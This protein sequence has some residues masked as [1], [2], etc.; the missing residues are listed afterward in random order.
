MHRNAQKRLALLVKVLLV[1]AGISYLA[2]VNRHLV[3]HAGKFLIDGSYRSCVHR[4]RNYELEEKSSP[5]YVT[6]RI[7]GRLG[8]WLF[9]YSSL[10][11]IAKANGY[12]PYFLS[13]HPLNSYFQLSHV[14]SSP[15]ECL[16]DVYDDLPC[17]YTSSMMNL[18][19]G[20][21]SIDGYIQSWKYFRFIEKELRQ[22]LKVH[23][24]LSLYAQKLFHK[25]L[26]PHI[27]AGRLVIS[28][29]V[30]RGDVLT[31]EARKLGF[32][33]APKE[34]FDNAMRYMLKLFPYSVF[35]VA[36]DDIEWCIDNIKPPILKDL[37]SEA[38]LSKIKHDNPKIKSS[39]FNERVPIVY[40]KSHSSWDDFSMLMLC[41]HS[42]I[43]VGTFGW[44]GAWFA[45]GHV[46]YY[47]G[48]PLPG[49]K[50]DHETNKED[51]FPSDWVALSTGAFLKCGT[52][53]FL[54]LF[55]TLQFTLILYK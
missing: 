38:K 11:G 15:A 27:A 18:P 42:I 55:F 31:P 50:I 41:N 28:I 53:F 37:L 20:N 29:H 36:S 21:I 2:W 47:D 19:S 54:L 49:S 32:C 26:G 8:N 51:F 39:V 45:K 23:P 13:S 9:G 4:R 25:H 1:V 5:L 3:I 10:L 48:F 16:F 46:V 44:W 24:H 40:S 6:K 34:Y 52:S 33:H 22:D 35:L 30:R 43:S 17:T 12:L 14:R 7:H